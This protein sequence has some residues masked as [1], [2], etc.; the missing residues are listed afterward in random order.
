MNAAIPAAGIAAVVL[1]AGSG[2]RLRNRLPKPLV[3]VDGV[4]LVVRTLSALRRALPGVRLIVPVAPELSARIARLLS[5]A[6]LAGA[7]LVPGGATRAESVRNGLAGVRESVVLVHD[8]ARPFV[9]A[10][11]LREAVEA[12]RRGGGA[13]LALPA[14]ATVKES[15]FS[16]PVIRRTLD[17]E[18]VWLAQTPQVFR[19]SVL[20]AAYAKLG[21]RASS[22]TDE[23]SI[24]E[25]AGGRVL[26]VEG[27]AF[28][29]KITTPEDLKL[30]HALIRL[31]LVK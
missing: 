29:L 13:I 10:P 30:A 3:S 16:G 24:V 27:T 6:G 23:A 12:A 17:R 26:L 19:T 9:P 20:R 22:C 11:R 7:E 31:K 1:A 5:R 15:R 2:T 8:V 18:R 25:K 4:P 14:T 28:N 21:S